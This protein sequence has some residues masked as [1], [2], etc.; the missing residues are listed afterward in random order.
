MRHL[1]AVYGLIRRV[2]DDD[3]GRAALVLPWHVP[4][5]RG[6][7]LCSEVCVAVGQRISTLIPVVTFVSSLMAPRSKA[8][9]SGC[10]SKSGQAAAKV[11]SV[12]QGRCE[13]PA[14]DAYSSWPCRLFLAFGERLS[15]IYILSHGKSASELSE[16]MR[17]FLGLVGPWLINATARVVQF[18]HCFQSGFGSSCRTRCGFGSFF[19]S[20][21]EHRWKRVRLGIFCYWW[22]PVCPRMRLPVRCRLKL[23]RG[24]LFDQGSWS[25]VKNCSSTLLT[26]R[27]YGALT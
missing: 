8:T 26:S 1:V 13:G 9:F 15:G 12:I 7:L 18:Q 20:T 10:G 5:A 27:T 25:V 4:S 17:V 11:G 16:D 14:D 21:L 24:S 3:Q 23:V 6:R 19:A 2:L 22:R